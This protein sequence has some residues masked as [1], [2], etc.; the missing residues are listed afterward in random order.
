M[1]S[2]DI[3]SLVRPLSGNNAAEVACWCSLS[4]VGPPSR[5][6]RLQTDQGTEFKGAVTQLMEVM[7]VDIIHSRPYNLQNPAGS[8]RTCMMFNLVEMVRFFV[9]T[10]AFDIATNVF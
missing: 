1:Y 7:Q 6:L 8:Y 3:S 9:K 5:S 10:N 2:L 4:D